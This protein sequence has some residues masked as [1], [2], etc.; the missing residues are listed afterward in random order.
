[1]L[2][3]LL[4]EA[5]QAAEAHRQVADAVTM[6]IVAVDVWVE[7]VIIALPLIALNNIV[8]LS[9]VDATVHAL[10]YQARHEVDRHLVGV[11]I[12][13][14][15]QTDLVYLFKH[16]IN[17]TCRHWCVCVCWYSETLENTARKLI[18]EN[19]LQAGLAFPTGV[20]IN[21]CAAHYT[22]NGGDDTVLQYDDV[23]KV[24]FGTH[25]QGHIID[26]A[27]TVTFNPRYDKL[28][29][30]VKDA[31]NTGVRVSGLYDV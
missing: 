30:A 18:K 22:P 23:M 1:M 10:H 7:L 27:F 3:G 13:N 8:Q 21:H 29:Q 5:R 11:I 26:S 19:G 25:V 20:S 12:E 31:T 4:K 15:I 16:A 9:F 24:D 2:D 6:T 28:L 17:Q 14:S